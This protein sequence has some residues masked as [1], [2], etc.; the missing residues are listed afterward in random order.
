M[1]M[2]M[3]IAASILRTEQKTKDRSRTVDGL[4]TA[5]EN[6]PREPEATAS[7]LGKG[8]SEVAMVACTSPRDTK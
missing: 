3:A 1:K 6:G 8:V 2:S 5:I 4:E 7:A